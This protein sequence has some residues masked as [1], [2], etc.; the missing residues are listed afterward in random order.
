[1]E[2]RKF[3]ILAIYNNDVPKNN[4]MLTDEGKLDDPLQFKHL[5][6]FFYYVC[7]DRVI[8]VVISENSQR[9]FFVIRFWINLILCPSRIRLRVPVTR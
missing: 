6:R 3:V 4:K 2:F 1:M 9:F 5:T 7:G 8:I